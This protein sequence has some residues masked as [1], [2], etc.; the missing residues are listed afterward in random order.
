MTEHSIVDFK[1]IQ[2]AHEL[3]RPLIHRTEI[4]TCDTLNRLA[5]AEL[6]FKCE[7]LQ[8]AGAFKSRG[9]CNAVFSLDHENAQRGVVTHSSGNHAAA[10]A[11]AGQMR[12]IPAHIVMPSN[13]PRVQ[14]AAVKNYAGQITFCEPT[15]ESRES[16]AIRVQQETEATFIHPYDNNQIIAGQG[17]AAVELLEDVPNLDV[18]IAPVGGGG[19]LSG[20]AIA[21]KALAPDIQV[22]AGEPENADDAYRSL[23]AGRVLP[24]ERNDTIADGLRTGLCERTF[25]IISRLVDDI[26]LVEEDAI[27]QAMQL[28][29][30]RA[31]LVVEPSAAVPLGAVMSHREKFTGL[32]VGI[33]LSGGN[34]D[35]TALP[36]SSQR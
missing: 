31:K 30:E 32:R 12:D 16:T 3:I 8:K 11:R 17:T 15:L 36:F 22:I 18:V 9:A 6:F 19:L 34:V 25:A 1:F 29:M 23:Q 4:T 26:L 2:Q 13:A 5:E 10:L 14:V 20:T 27:L 7:H 33:I 35:L 28:L 24:V 21:A